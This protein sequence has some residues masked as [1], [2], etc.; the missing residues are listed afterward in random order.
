VRIVDARNAPS[1]HEGDFIVVDPDVAA[2]SGDMV[3]AIIADAPILG[4]YAIR[5]SR[6]QL[7]S[8]NRKWPVCTLE[9]K[10]GDRIVG[11]VTEHAQPRA[12]ER[13]S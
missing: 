11:V 5:G 9:K 4:K 8:I 3:V 1:Y 12:G 7:L 10:R 13:V 6:I 2:S